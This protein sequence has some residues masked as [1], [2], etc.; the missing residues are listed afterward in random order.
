MAVKNKILN[1]IL[2]GSDLRHTDSMAVDLVGKCPVTLAVSTGNSVSVKFPMEKEAFDQSKAEIAQRV[3]AYKVGA[4]AYQGGMVVLDLI[5]WKSAKEAYEGVR[6]V[7]RELAAPA[8]GDAVCPY[9]GQGGCDTA[10]LKDGLYAKMHER[11][12]GENEERERERIEGSGN[13]FTGLLGALGGALLVLAVSLLLIVLTHTSFG[14]L[15]AFS[16]VVAMVGYLACKGRYG[17][18]GA[19]LVGGCSLLAF[20]AFLYAEALFFLSE[21]GI[22]FNMSNF[23]EELLALTEIVFSLDYLAES[24]FEILFFVIGLVLTFMGRPLSKAK[25][26][27]ELDQ[28]AA[29]AVPLSG[30]R[31][32]LR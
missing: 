8:S 14:W 23:L 3:K 6:E 21:A 2:S 25:R 32:D 15:Y 1:A 18:A 10:A 17:I 11:C 13:Y 9:C 30:E 16:T 31:A 24:W 12:R 27:G 22:Y 28:M 29:L 4:P 5:N 26:A 19:F 7:I 20:V